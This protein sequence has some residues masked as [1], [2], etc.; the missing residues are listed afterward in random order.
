MIERAKTM[1]KDWTRSTWLLMGLVAGLSTAPMPAAGQVSLATVVDL[2]EKNSIPVQMAN[3]E[4]ARARATLSETK[5]A[6][7]PSVVASS[8]LPTFPEVGFTGDVPSIWTAS[9]QSLIFGLPQKRYINAARL[10]LRAASSRLHDAQEQVV[11]DASTAYIELDATN[12][13]M[14]AARA[15]KRFADRLVEIEQARAEAGVDPLSELLQARLT[16][17]QVKL[18]LLH[19]E[20]RGMT[21]S[22]QLAALTG[23]PT[24]S[25]VPD[26]ASIPEIPK[27][28]GDARRGISPGTESAQLLA[29]SKVQAAKGDKEINYLPQLSF[30]A[31]YNRNT[32]L[33]NEVNT[34]FA[35]SLP[36]NNFSSGISIEV[37][38]FDMG[39][40]AK[41]RE[42]AAE[43]LQARVEAEQAQKQDDL[44]VA[45]LNGALRE[46]N[47]LS[48]VATLK[49]EIAAE[50][51]KSVMTQL[52][53]GNGAG[54]G[55][56]GPPQLGPKAEQLARVDEREK[57]QE[58]LRAQLD[59]DKTRLGLLHALGHIGDW[60][61]ELHGMK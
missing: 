29:A 9:V 32:T 36:A 19:L 22:A 51:L 15:Q 37:P 16:A 44:R 30:G 8:G 14:D 53:S 13:E 55:P 23:L 45:D 31:R 28:R 43:A 27:L 4:V 57:Y 10:G 33:L 54:V 40:R 52:E 50:Q 60:L 56:G 1:T 12:R 20:A 39:R 24:G 48:E 46:L 35:K 21:V 3:A 59:L 47:A 7:I 11:L 41:A 61:N 26:H 17:A 34:Y 18:K 6:T 2:A 42:T 38:I 5:D 58:A 25:I 49:Q